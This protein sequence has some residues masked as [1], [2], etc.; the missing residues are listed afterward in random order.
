MVFNK[1][2]QAYYMFPQYRFGDSAPKDNYVFLT[3]VH[4]LYA[5]VCN[6]ETFCGNYVGAY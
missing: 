6:S 4:G 2:Y 1:H 3:E 5:V